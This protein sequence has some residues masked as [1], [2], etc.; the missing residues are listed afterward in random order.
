MKEDIDELSDAYNDKIR[1]EL[2]TAKYELKKLRGEFE[3]A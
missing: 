3:K 1:K 2:E